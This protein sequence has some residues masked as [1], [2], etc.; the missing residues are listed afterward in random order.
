M[1][2]QQEFV[3]MIASL[4]WTAP[5]SCRGGASVIERDI[6]GLLESPCVGLKDR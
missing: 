3:K 6:D 2:T 5:L 1:Y 4:S